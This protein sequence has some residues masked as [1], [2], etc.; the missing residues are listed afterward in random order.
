MPVSVLVQLTQIAATRQVVRV[1]NV[2]GAF[3]DEV[4][5]ERNDHVGTV[6][7]IQR[8]D[9]LAE[10]HPRAF[11]YGMTARRIVLMP[12]GLRV[13]LQKRFELR[14]ERR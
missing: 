8:I 2:A 13:R 5:I 14:G 9:V 6:E 4:G 10:G 3:H 12:P 1:A 7:V 11:A